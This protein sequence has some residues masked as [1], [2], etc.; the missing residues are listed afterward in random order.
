MSSF[1][2]KKE[3]PLT[4]ESGALRDETYM[5][6]FAECGT[7]WGRRSS[8]PSGVAPSLNRASASPLQ[9][10]CR[11]LAGYAGGRV[12]LAIENDVPEPVSSSTLFFC[13][14]T[15][16]RRFRYDHVRGHDRTS[17]GSRLRVD[18]EER[19]WRGGEQSAETFM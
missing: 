4:C 2:S 9:S 13:Q 18:S 1:L 15:S 8:R 6:D 16:W 17:V 12:D 19:V 14:P 5:K 11:R 7:G 3:Q 10:G